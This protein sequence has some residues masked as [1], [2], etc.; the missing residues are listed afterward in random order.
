M[1]ADGARRLSTFAEAKRRAM[2]EYDLPADQDASAWGESPDE[3]T[4]A[5]GRLPG[6]TYASTSFI[7]NRPSSRDLGQPARFV[8]KVFDTDGE[9]RVV[10]DGTEWL[11]SETP[12]GRYQI[13]LLVAREAGA[14]KELWIQRV[15]SAG[16]PEN[17]K[18]LANLRREDAGRLVEL[19]RNL[20]CIPIEGCKA[21]TVDDA[22][23]RDLFADPDSLV[24][25]YRQ[26]PARF[27]KL[28]TDDEAA[29]DVV[30]L[31]YRRNQVEHFRRLLND[32]DFFDREVATHKDSRRESVWQ[33]FFEQNPWILGVTLA[34]QLVT[35]WNHDKLEQVVAGPSVAGAGKRIDALMRTAGRIRSMI[36]AEFKRH[37][38]HLLHKEHRSGCWSPSEDLAGGVAQAQGTVY[39]AVRAI[40]ERLADA[41][42][43]GSELPGQFTYLIR[44]RS[45]LI[46]GQLTDLKGESGGD[47]VDR[48]RSF[49]LY[50][51]QLEEPEVITYDELLARAEWFVTT[52]ADAD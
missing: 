23:V 26:D 42:P 28:I 25:I 3:A 50:R 5:Q 14:V 35:S 7:I 2:S 19:L 24:A 40:G 18:V 52:S 37:D 45:F 34:G 33:R 22:L 36:F 15:P 11:I 48:I 43:D 16:S 31:T 47:H 29:R 27:R 12:R 9:T 38:A 44:P 8:H 39:R 51:R 46:V 49:E 21:V 41:A 20:D 17:V 4:F 10:Y 13:K 30:A 32:S 6:R 1:A